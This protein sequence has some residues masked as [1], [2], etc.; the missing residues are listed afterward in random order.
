ML[1]VIGSAVLVVALVPYLYFGGRDNRFH[2]SL[3]KVTKAEHFIHAVI[4]LTVIALGVGVFR[5]DVPQ[6]V[7]ALALFVPPALVDELVFHREL[8]S[9]E[10]AVHAKTHLMLF[11]FVIVGALVAALESGV[12][13][14]R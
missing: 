7:L 6:A 10:H 4:L 8:P 13:S 14:P 3:R 12:L 1:E 9:E 5:R 11:V 2:F